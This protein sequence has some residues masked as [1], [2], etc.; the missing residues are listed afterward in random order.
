MKYGLINT[1]SPGRVIRRQD[2]GTDTPPVQDDGTKWVKDTPPVFDDTKQ[3]RDD[4]AAI[5]VN[6][7]EVPYVV[8]DI[9]LERLRGARKELIEKARYA[10]EIGG[11]VVGGIPVDTD[12]KS[13]TVMMEVFKAMQD[14]FVAGPVKLKTSTG[15][16][17]DLDIAAM[18]SIASATAAHVQG[19]FQKES[20]LF[21]AID[22]ASTAEDIRT[23]GWT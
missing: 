1:A 3:T 12:R 6:A 4:V 23:V 13:R 21:A 11:I 22:A 8:T 14:G 15:F 9:P 10:T 20:R 18:T 2:F 17:P 5:P 19:A 7:T 16:T